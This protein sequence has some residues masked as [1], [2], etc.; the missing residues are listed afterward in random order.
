MFLV[1]LCTGKII[2]FIEFR[3]GATKHNGSKAREK[4]WVSKHRSLDG[5]P[6]VYNRFEL[7]RNLDQ[8]L[9]VDERR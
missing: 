1:E 6:L 5:A 3:E 2:L 9:L 7:Q 4:L 8:R